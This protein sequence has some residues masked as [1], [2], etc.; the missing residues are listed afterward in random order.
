MVC[1]SLLVRLNTPCHGYTQ[2]CR[3]DKVPRGPVRLW[4]SHVIWVFAID[5]GLISPNA[6]QPSGRILINIHPIWKYRDGRPRVK[7]GRL[8][9]YT[10]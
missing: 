6:P 2:I 10:V 1:I 9:E 8:S 7:V 4:W 5:R 3:T